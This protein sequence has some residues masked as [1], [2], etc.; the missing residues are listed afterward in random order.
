EKIEQLLKE[1]AQAEFFN[2]APLWIEIAMEEDEEEECD[3]DD[4]ECLKRK[5]ERE[6]SWLA[7]DSLRPSR[8]GIYMPT[9]LYEETEAGD[10][11]IQ[12]SSLN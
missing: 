8:F 1:A 7:P 11:V 6:T 2:K 12:L 10:L 3:P 5:R 4:E 9:L